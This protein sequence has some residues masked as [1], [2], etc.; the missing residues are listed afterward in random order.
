MTAGQSERSRVGKAH[1]MAAKRTA[2]PRCAGK[3]AYRSARSGLM[4][5]CH[6]CEGTGRRG[7]SRDPADDNEWTARVDTQDWDGA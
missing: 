1:A 2:C 7:G 3:G 6:P 4:V 5:P